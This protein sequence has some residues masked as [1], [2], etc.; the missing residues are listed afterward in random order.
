M[1]AGKKLSYRKREIS[2]IESVIKETSL[3]HRVRKNP[4][5]KV[6]DTLLQLLDNSKQN[7]M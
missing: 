5:N 7:I 6:N 4:S 3:T 1:K 2:K